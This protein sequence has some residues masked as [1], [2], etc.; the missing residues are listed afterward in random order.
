MYLLKN[1]FWHNFHEPPSMARIRHRIMHATTHDIDVVNHGSERRRW[2]AARAQRS[3]YCFVPSAGGSFPSANDEKDTTFVGQCNGAVL[4][5]R[6]VSVSTTFS[7]P[8]G[9]V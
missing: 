7:Q 3:R 8:Q 6:R 5:E 9:A 4:C 1:G 2:A